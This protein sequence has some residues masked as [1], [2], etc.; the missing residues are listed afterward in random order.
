MRVNA[1]D[2]RKADRRVFGGMAGL[3]LVDT[4]GAAHGGLRPACRA[5]VE[6]ADKISWATIKTGVQALPARLTGT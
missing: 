3:Q 5:N 1:A 2:G 4:Q 6:D